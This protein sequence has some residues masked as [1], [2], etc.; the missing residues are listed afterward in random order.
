MSDRLCAKELAAALGRAAGYVSAMR[1]SGFVMPGGMAT[2]DEALDWL[3]RH[4][5]FRRRLIYPP[6]PRVGK[7]RESKGKNGKAIGV[8]SL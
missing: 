6:K 1:R 2:P 7:E 4:P 5:E 8:A 3:R